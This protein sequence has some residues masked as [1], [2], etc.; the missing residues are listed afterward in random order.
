MNRVVQSARRALLALALASTA[1]SIASAQT[2][3]DPTRGAKLFQQQCA[4]CHVAANGAEP[5][6]PSL[7]GVVGRHAGAVG[8]FK[9]SKAMLAA[10]Q[11]WTPAVLEAFLA[12]PTKLLPGTQMVLPVPSAQQRAD[13]I[14]YLG[15]VK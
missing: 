9:Y 3:G 12:A 15:T 1:I 11:V 6:G 2:A 10:N 4:V 13:I 7:A 14:S 8:G 5:L